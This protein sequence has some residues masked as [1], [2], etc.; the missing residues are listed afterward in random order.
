M[1]SGDRRTLKIVLFH[2]KIA[3]SASYVINCTINQ[4]SGNRQTLWQHIKTHT[5]IHWYAE[6]AP[7]HAVPYDRKLSMQNAVTRLRDFMILPPPSYKYFVILWSLNAIN[8]VSSAYL[9]FFVCCLLVPIRNSLADSSITV[10][11]Q[12]KTLSFVSFVRHFVV[13]LFKL[14][15][16]TILSVE[17]A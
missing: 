13:V 15:F 8:G 17:R 12:N 4:L 10:H 5:H 11:R 16:E 1:H 9:S 6:V 2:G 14:I 3:Q 7:C